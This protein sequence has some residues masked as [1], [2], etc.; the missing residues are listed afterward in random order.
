MSEFKYTR[1]QEKSNEEVANQI[2]RIATSLIQHAIDLSDDAFSPVHNPMEDNAFRF[3]SQGGESEMRL[4]VR[5]GSMTYLTHFA[6]GSLRLTQAVSKSDVL[7][8]ATET[9]IRVDEYSPE[10]YAAGAFQTERDG[11]S[12]TDWEQLTT[13]ETI[14][15]ASVM[16]GTLR[17]SLSQSQRNAQASAAFNRQLTNYY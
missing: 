16:L 8:E 17:S 2:R 11:F 1:R 6:D 14:H 5:A 12:S 4:D 7:S 3:Y 15:Y 10:K 13:S 9:T